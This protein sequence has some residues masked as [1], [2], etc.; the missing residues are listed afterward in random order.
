[1][2]EL[3]GL[4]R[5]V[6]QPLEGNCALPPS[7]FQWLK[8]TVHFGSAGRGSLPHERREKTYADGK[9]KVFLLF[10]KNFTGKHDDLVEPE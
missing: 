6:F 4:T 8:K 10:S 9:N 1:L 3:C 5:S 2:E 7:G